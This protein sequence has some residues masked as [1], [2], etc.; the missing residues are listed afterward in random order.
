MP[1]RYWENYSRKAC[2][3][4]FNF[5]RPNIRSLKRKSVGIGDGWAL[6]ASA[7]DTPV[8]SHVYSSIKSRGKQ[9]FTDS[10][11]FF[12]EWGGSFL[13]MQG[14]PRTTATCKTILLSTSMLLFAVCLQS[15]VIRFVSFLLS[16]FFN[17]RNPIE[18]IRTLFTCIVLGVH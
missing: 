16:F 6:R 5:P 3:Y 12:H 8:I 14:W 18:V 2:F 4:Y 15:F 11:L 7:V 17:H 9:R 1:L 10:G 13:G